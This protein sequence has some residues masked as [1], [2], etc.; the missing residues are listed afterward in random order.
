MTA[1]VLV[2]SNDVSRDLE[3]TPEQVKTILNDL[4]YVSSHLALAGITNTGRWE[5]KQL[6]RHGPGSEKK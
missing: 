2:L 3:L 1:R 6:L 5:I 4:D